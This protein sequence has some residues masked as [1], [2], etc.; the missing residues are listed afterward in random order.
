MPTPAPPFRSDV[1]S[2]T[3]AG[4]DLSAHV[5]AVS[6][7][8]DVAENDTPTL[9]NPAQTDV[10][11]I[12]WRATI[13]GWQSFDVDGGGEGLYDKLAPLVDPTIYQTMVYEPIAGGTASFTAQAKLPVAPIGEFEPGENVEVE[14]DLPLQSE[15]VYANTATPAP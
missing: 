15:P 9:T 2:L 8:P 3:F 10:G 5:R 13:R 14:V 12:T 1:S 11:T 4:V 6:F 7:E